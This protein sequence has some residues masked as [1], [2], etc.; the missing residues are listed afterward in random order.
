MSDADSVGK[1]TAI[2]TIKA[3]MSATM[4]RRALALRFNRPRP[5]DRTEPRYCRPLNP[6]KPADC[7]YPR[8]FGGRAVDVLGTLARVLDG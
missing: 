8:Q 3:P 5:R 6:P 1:L 4:S 2:D 7:G